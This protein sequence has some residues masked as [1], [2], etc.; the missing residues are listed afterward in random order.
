VPN[1]SEKL[2]KNK[3]VNSPSPDSDKKPIKN[4][5]EALAMIQ[6]TPDKRNPSKYQFDESIR[7]ENENKGIMI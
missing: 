2:T 1:T 7:E 5:F 6:T 3:F 4:N